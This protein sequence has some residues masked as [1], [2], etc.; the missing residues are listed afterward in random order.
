MV[1]YG[2]TVITPF[3]GVITS[4]SKNTPDPPQPATQ[5]SSPEAACKRPARGA[6]QPYRYL[7]QPGCCLVR[8]SPPHRFGQVQ[9]RASFL[10]F[11]SFAR[12][13]AGSGLRT[14]IG[15]AM[16]V[17]AAPPWTGL[18]QR[19]TQASAVESG[20]HICACQPPPPPPPYASSLLFCCC[21]SC[22]GCCCRPTATAM[23]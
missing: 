6:R 4:D 21:C 23:R 20:G 14:T 19:A 17:S 7:A 1:W 3:S 11:R 13:P 10:D 22:C 9:P 2:H 8:T 5:R 15:S 12:K 18:G 16:E